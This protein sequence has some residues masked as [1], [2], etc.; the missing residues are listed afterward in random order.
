M[1]P[2]RLILSWLILP[3]CL[4]AKSQ[5]TAK[6]I[7]RTDTIK[8]VTK[9]EKFYLGNKKLQ[10]AEMKPMLMKYNSSAFEFKQYQKRAT[11]G[12]FPWFVSSR[13][14]PAY[15]LTIRHE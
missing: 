7:L 4:N 11:P 13:T 15:S 8:Y 9:S 12:T 2:K 6:T 14:I 1:I 10:V 3:I 5:D